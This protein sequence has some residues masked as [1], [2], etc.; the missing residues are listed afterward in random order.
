MCIHYVTP[1]GQTYCNCRKSGD[2]RTK[3]PA[4]VNCPSCKR[5]LCDQMS[6]DK[7]PQH[8]AENMAAGAYHSPQQERRNREALAILLAL[9]IGCG[10]LFTVL[11]LVAKPV[12]AA[13]ICVGV[14]SMVWLAVCK[15]A[16]RKRH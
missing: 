3:Q 7:W 8:V 13:L 4:E 5:L 6:A 15:N 16:N 10:S 2:R 1:T 12:G 11:I 9:M 14:A